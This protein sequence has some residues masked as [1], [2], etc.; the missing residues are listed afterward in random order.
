LQ[1]ITVAGLQRISL[2]ALLAFVCIWVF[3]APAHFSVP[4]V[5]LGAV[6]ILFGHAGFLATEFGLLVVYGVDSTVRRPTGS[7]LVRAWATEVIHASRVFGWRQPWRSDSFSDWVPSSRRCGVVLVHGFFCNR[8]FWNPWMARLRAIQVPYVAVNLEPPFG[9]IDDYAE[10]I[11]SAVRRVTKATGQPPF[12]VAHS[13]GGLAVRAWLARSDASRRVR[14]IFTLGTPHRGT[15]LARFS[16]TPSGKQMRIGSRWLDDLA[17][18]EATRNATSQFVCYYS[19]CDNIVF[20]AS[21]ATLP[22][23]ER[24]HVEGLAHVHM[25]FDSLVM[26][27][28]VTEIE[29]AQKELAETRCS[30]LRG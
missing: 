5:L 15:W 25:A 12:I 19:N 23:A 18:L 3:L 2:A 7:Q 16:L 30:P 21:L 22:G 11:E 27:K 6:A 4:W 1:T 26:D 28:V 24:R 8:G 17:K 20:P 13:M 9:S 29:E 14:R 10:R